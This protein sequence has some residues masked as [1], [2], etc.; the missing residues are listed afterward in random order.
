MINDVTSELLSLKSNGMTIARIIEDLYNV[1]KD[2]NAAEYFPNAT[3]DALFKGNKA[4][5]KF[6]DCKRDVK[7]VVKSVFA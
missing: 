3:K 1:T 6:K 5:S 2:F 7:G 4:E